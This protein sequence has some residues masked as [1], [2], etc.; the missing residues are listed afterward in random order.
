MN[1]FFYGYSE[2][3]YAINELFVEA[4]QNFVR[5]NE[6][7]RELFKVNEI[8]NALYKEYI[9]VRAWINSW[10]LTC[11]IINAFLSRILKLMI[12]YFLAKGINMCMQM[13]STMMS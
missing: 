7:Y 11:G 12:Q 3:L 9:W 13:Q 2:K 10:E 1:E 6:Q 5:N 4:V 8:A